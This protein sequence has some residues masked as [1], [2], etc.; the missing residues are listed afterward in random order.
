MNDHDPA[1]MRKQ[2]R[3]DGLDESVRRRE[4]RGCFNLGRAYESGLVGG[5]ASPQRARPHY[6]RA[7]TGGYPPAS[8]RVGPGTSP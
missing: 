3:A 5:T 1:L 6:Q 2:Y 4:M 7:C 8:E